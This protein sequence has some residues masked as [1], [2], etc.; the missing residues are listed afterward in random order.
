VKQDPTYL[1]VFSILE[2]SGSILHAETVGLSL[3]L[4]LL[5]TSYKAVIIY[6]Q[7]TTK[8]V[9]SVT[10]AARLLEPTIPCQACFE[11]IQSGELLEG[12]QQTQDG[13]LCRA[14]LRS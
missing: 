3:Q 12:E 13:N 9:H 4:F 8:F 2:I 10:P 5:V 6:L 14:W 1:I 7:V 11:S